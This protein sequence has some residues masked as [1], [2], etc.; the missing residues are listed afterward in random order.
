M[1]ES[2]ILLIDRRGRGDLVIFGVM[3]VLTLAVVWVLVA[4]VKPWL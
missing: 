1:S 2:I 3:A 4:W